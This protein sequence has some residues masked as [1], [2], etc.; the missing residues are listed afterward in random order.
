MLIAVSSYE[1]F[2]NKGS[3]CAHELVGILGLCLEFEEH[4]SFW[5]IHGNNVS[6][7]MMLIVLS[8][9]PLKSVCCYNCLDELHGFLY[10]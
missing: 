10:Q 9:K 3:S 7:H 2:T 1:A 8:V 4:I 5:H 6:C